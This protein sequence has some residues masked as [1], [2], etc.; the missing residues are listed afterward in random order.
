MSKALEYAEKSMFRNLSMTQDGILFYLFTEK[1]EGATI[2][3]LTERFY[4]MRMNKEL[5]PYTYNPNSAYA[6]MSRTVKRLK[7]RGIVETRKEGRETIVYLTYIEF[8]ET[9]NR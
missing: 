2:K 7:E 3:H 6:S 8:A 4:S 9:L 5:Y 1:P